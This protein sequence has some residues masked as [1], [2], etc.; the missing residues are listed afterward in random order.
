MFRTFNNENLEGECDE[1]EDE[2]KCPMGYTPTSEPGGGACALPRV[3]P[4]ALTTRDVDH[5]DLHALP[6]HGREAQCV[7]DEADL[8]AA[9][10][11]QRVADE[12]DLVAAFEAQCVADEADRID[13]R[14]ATH[15]A[16]ASLQD[17]EEARRIASLQDEE[18]AHRIAAIQVANHLAMTG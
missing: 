9:F 12:A 1:A 17:E 2:Q 5:P 7:A 13:A 16:I 3:L 11:A 15:V 10:E 4:R 18:E 14:V 6:P 8:V